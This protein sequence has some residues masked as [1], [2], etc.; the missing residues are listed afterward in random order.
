MIN[1]KENPETQPNECHNSLEMIAS[2][3]Q[4]NACTTVDVDKEWESD[5]YDSLDIGEDPNVGSP[6]DV[7]K[8]DLASTKGL[9]EG[10]FCFYYQTFDFVLFFQIN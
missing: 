1:E 7:L 8:Y 3:H 10:N 2:I 4:R 5:A 9:A 6:I